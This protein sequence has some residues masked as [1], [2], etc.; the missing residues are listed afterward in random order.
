M[1]TKDYETEVARQLEAMGIGKGGY[2][3]GTELERLLAGEPDVPSGC[4]G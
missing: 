2:M 3:L 1:G 4:K